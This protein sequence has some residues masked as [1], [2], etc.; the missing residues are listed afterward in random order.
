MIMS[1]ASDFGGRKPGNRYCR[2]CA[3]PDGNLRP[4]YEVQANMVAHYMKVKRMSQ[5]DAEQY[6][7]EIMA[8]CPAW[9]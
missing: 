8:G 6:V 9:K 4:R 3:Y 7:A 2:H 1:S 5:P